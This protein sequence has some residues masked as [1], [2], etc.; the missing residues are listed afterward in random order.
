[1]R[2]DNNGKTE[3]KTDEDHLEEIHN[4]IEKGKFF[5][6]TKMLYLLSTDEKRREAQALIDDKITQNIENARNEDDEEISFY[7]LNEDISKL[8]KIKE[9]VNTDKEKALEFAKERDAYII[10]TV[11]ELFKEEEIQLK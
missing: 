11:D 6:A 5:L 8:K 10:I 1:M 4:L 2:I 3:S 9:I 7:E